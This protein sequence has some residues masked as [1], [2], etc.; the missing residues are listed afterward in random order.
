M[1]LLQYFLL[2]QKVDGGVSFSDLKSVCC[3]SLKKSLQCCCSLSFSECGDLSGFFICSFQNLA[4]LEFF[5]LSVFLL[6]HCAWMAGVSRAVFSGLSAP[7]VMATCTATAM[8]RVRR[9][10]GGSGCELPVSMCTHLS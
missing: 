9:G 7:T 3:I 8:G 5:W 4:Y 6:F 10:F 2:P 1:V